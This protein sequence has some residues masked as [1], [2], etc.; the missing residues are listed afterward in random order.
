VIERAV[1][2]TDRGRRR[3]TCRLHAAAEQHHLRGL[4][5]IEPLAPDVLHVVEHEA[6]KA[7]ELVLLRA[8]LHRFSGRG[9]GLGTAA[10]AEAARALTAETGAASGEHAGEDETD[11]HALP[12][13]HAEQPDDA[14][15]AGTA[16]TKASEAG[17]AL[18]ASVLDIR[19]RIV[20]I[21][22]HD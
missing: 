21:P 13:E 16:T 9:R 6:D 17:A 4:V 8:A 10:H 22:A 20:S 1:E 7:D 15:H 2:R 12:T 18:A 19:A 14:E 3:A 5:V 11:Q